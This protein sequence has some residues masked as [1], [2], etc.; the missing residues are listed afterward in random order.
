MKGFSHIMNLTNNSFIAGINKIVDSILLCLLFFL[1]CIP[2]F[3]IGASITSLYYTMLKVIENDR[4]YIS[5][6]FFSCFK[7][8]F[9]QST[10]VWL[11]LLA[12][13]AFLCFD[14]IIMKSALSLG[15]ASGYLY[16]VFLLLMALI[17]IW[18]L[19]FFPYIARFEDSTKNL[20]RNTSMIALLNLP[21]TILLAL[22]FVFAWALIYMC[23]AVAI[24]MPVM[25][26]L[27]KVKIIERIFIQ[28]MSPED[29]EAE[30]ERNRIY[31]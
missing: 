8:N 23:P 18:S 1:C 11:L 25:Y 13:Y 20:L 21:W 26:H 28:Y 12:V 24:V 5:T 14:F 22:L 2:V 16:Y 3:T 29:I 7:K 10:L 27:F 30:E 6:E 19:Y 31:Y 4:G 17:T 15:D 9:K